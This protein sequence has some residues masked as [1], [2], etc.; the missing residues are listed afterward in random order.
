MQFTINQKQRL[1][2]AIKAQY[3]QFSWTELQKLIQE[4]QVFI[5]KSV[6]APL[7]GGKILEHNP[8]KKSEIVN[9]G[10][11]VRL[12]IKKEKKIID[13]N[14]PTIP[15]VF[16]NKDFI[17]VNKPA[18]ICVHSENEGTSLIDIV[19]GQYG[20]KLYAVHRLDKD[21]C[22]LII[23]AC[24]ATTQRE[25]Q[26][27]FKQREIVKKYYAVC[28]S[29]HPKSKGIIE[30][31]LKNIHKAKKVKIITQADSKY[32][33]TQFELIKSFKTLHLYDIR[34]FTGRTHQIRVHMQ[35][36]GLPIL[37]DIVYG[38]SVI[39]KRYSCFVQQLQ[40]YYLAFSFEKKEYE[41]K[42]DCELPIIKQL[43]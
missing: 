14:A 1:D 24:T 18:G 10:D 8:K 22:G 36:V 7:S 17:V 34:I 41:F 12:V 21:T 30:A 31:A 42:I 33:L 13:K 27:L 19:T 26:S 25:L 3:P 4:G 6:P 38:D 29:E 9:P 5:L 43:F 40:S 2:Y 35:M 16:Q 20:H 15:I 11:K 23:F 28:I 32:A 39:N 37:G